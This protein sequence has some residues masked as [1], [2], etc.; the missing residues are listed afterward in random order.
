MLDN[1]SLDRTSYSYSNY[2]DSP[3]FASYFNSKERIAYYLS[4]K[5]VDKKRGFHDELIKVLEDF[6]YYVSTKGAEDI[7]D[8]YIFSRKSLDE[9]VISSLEDI[10]RIKEINPRG[11]KLLGAEEPLSFQDLK[12]SYK[13]AAKQHHPDKGGIHEDMIA[14]NDAFQQFHNLLCLMQEGKTSIR[15]TGSEYLLHE[16]P[17]SARDYVYS[18]KMLLAEVYLDDWNLDKAFDS[19]IQ[20]E[21][22]HNYK[23]YIER[24]LLR[25]SKFT[26][27]ITKRLFSTG[28][29]AKSRKAQELFTGIIK[30]IIARDIGN[31]RYHME[32]LEKVKRIMDGKQKPRVTLNHI[33]QAENALRLGVI[34][35]DKFTSLVVKFEGKSEDLKKKEELLKEY[36][37]KRG[38][39]HE[40][41]YDTNANRSAH[42]KSLIP[43]PQ[44][45]GNNIYLLD[46]DQQAE[47]FIAFSV[48]T[49]L[50]LVNKYLFVRLDSLINSV[51]RNFNIT[52]F[53]RS[54][55][56]LEVLESLQD[57]KSSGIYYIEKILELFHFFR[58]LGENDR[59]ER[60]ELIVKISDEFKGKLCTE[61]GNDRLVDG[62]PRSFT[63]PR[64]E[65]IIGTHL[66]FFGNAR[67]PLGDLREFYKIAIA[68]EAY[69]FNIVI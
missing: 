53:E 38:F 1:G 32:R 10:N 23:P 6:L 41:P 58:D 67:S 65:L 30:Q 11:C 28:L 27:S 43:E 66:S 3:L 15:D 9:F 69:E 34:D 22:E 33:R 48:K 8:E 26:E 52:L 20:I 46:N 56:E 21:E 40:L 55:N 12:S 63:Q 60:L 16:V 51:I 14:I 68:S 37:G 61:P 49:N 54:I 18:V 2:L 42:K 13:E 64:A 25:I 50:S 62:L 35:D 7:L 4:L 5:H 47:Y 39:I 59:T 29:E 45:Y 57:P 36:I 24:E 31:N 44:Y 17:K 19:F